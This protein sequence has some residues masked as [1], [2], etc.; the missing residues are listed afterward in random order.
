MDSGATRFIISQV[1][2]LA[3]QP[4][5]GEVVEVARHSMLDWLGIAIAGASEPLVEKLREEARELGGRPLASVIRHGERTSPYFAA[6]INGS[7]ADA[8]DFSDA[9]VAMRG[10]TTP[11]VVAATLALAEA[12]QLSGREVVLGIVAGVE[13]ECR[14]GLAAHPLRKGF[15]PTGN[16]APFGCAAAASQLLGLDEL[17]WNHAFGI[18]R[19]AGRRTARLRRDDVQAASLRTRRGEWR[20]CGQAREA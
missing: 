14:A 2:A 10:H 6:L 15:H 9:N 19:D 1:R 3:A 5:P 17:Q 20:A 18:A 11:G 8:L 12:G 4:L 7:A 13:A 16:L